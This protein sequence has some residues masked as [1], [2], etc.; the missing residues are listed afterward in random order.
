MYMFI[1]YNPRCFF[2]KKDANVMSQRNHRNTIISRAK[3][4]MKN[5]KCL[6]CGDYG[7]PLEP[8]LKQCVCG[9]FEC[10]YKPG[11]WWLYKPA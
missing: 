4:R 2:T 5:L 10:E 7:R 11:E 3:H 8:R 6:N 1:S 9:K